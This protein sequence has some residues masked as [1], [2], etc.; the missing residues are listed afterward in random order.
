MGP[1][2]IVKCIGQGTELINRTKIPRLQTHKQVNISSLECTRL[3]YFRSNL[4]Q[5]T[6]Q[7][8]RRYS[9][10]F[11]QIKL[12]FELRIVNCNEWNI[13][14]DIHTKAVTTGA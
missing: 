5:H 7:S 6:Q 3:L 14:R 10:H 4:S 9:T 13:G 11:V 8:T 12:A 1:M 2:V